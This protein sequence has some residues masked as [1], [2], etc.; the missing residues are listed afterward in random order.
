MGMFVK[1]PKCSQDAQGFL[2]QRYQPVLVALGI[3]DMNPHIAAINIT[4][5]E[6]DTLSE[7]QT[8]AVGGKEKDPVTQ[9][10]G[11]AKQPV[12]LFDRKYVWNSGRLGWF[13]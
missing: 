8:H 11:F 2:G 10:V 6:F 5:C 9:L 13:D 3:A 12:Q 7:T 4:N 1:C